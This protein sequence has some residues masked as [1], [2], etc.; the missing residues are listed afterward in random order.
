M[1]DVR[2]GGIDVIETTDRS[3]VR[4]WGEIDGALRDEASAALAS[5]LERDLPVSID[6]RDVTFIDSTGVAFLV[7][8]CAIGVHEDLQV[9]LSAPSPVVADVVDMLDIRDA[10]RFETDDDT[11]RAEPRGAGERPLAVVA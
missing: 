8:F 7:Q 5:S 3:T 4:L 10:L 11:R 1:R 9:A 6:T 2:A